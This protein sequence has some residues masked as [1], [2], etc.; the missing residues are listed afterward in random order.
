V[1]VAG[2]LLTALAEVE[3]PLMLKDLAAAARMAPAKAHRYLVSLARLRLVSQDEY[4]RYDLGPF[5]LALGLAALNRLDAIKPASRAIETLRDELGETV[6]LVTWGTHGAT[7]IRIA[8][9]MRAVTVSPRVGAI[10]PLTASASGFVFAAFLPAAMIEPV[11]ARELEGRER[12]SPHSPA[13]PRMKSRKALETIAAK[14]RSE[15]IAYAE[16]AFAPGIN[17]YAVPVVDH[18]GRVALAITVIGYAEH[19]GAGPGTKVALALQNA[20]QQVSLA[21]GYRGA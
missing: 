9:P 7:C 18:L 14:V 1:E 4:G 11:L 20:A 16:S 21:L 12:L 2:P 8:E 5:A 15:G 10:A 13:S 19:L 6:G 3:A 17:S